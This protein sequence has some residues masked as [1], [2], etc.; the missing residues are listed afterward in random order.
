MNPF[1]LAAALGGFLIFA[2]AIQILFNS[3]AIWLVVKYMVDVGG[4]VKYWRCLLCAALLILAI[5]L[6]VPC[7]LIPIPVLNLILFLIVWYKVSIV[8]IEA[9]ME[10]H[11]GA[12]SILILYLITGWLIGKFIQMLASAAA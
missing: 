8:V 1:V 10:I 6:A 12:L 9:S 5:V 4:K 2:I 11:Q 7:L 3:V